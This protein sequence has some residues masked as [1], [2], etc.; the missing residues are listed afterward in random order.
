VNATKIE[1]AD[2]R[3]NPITGCPGPKI[4]PGCDHCY[5]E[6][7]AKRLAGRYGY[8]RQDPFSLHQHHDRWL[9]P[10]GIKKPSRI[11]VCSMGDLFHHG[12]FD[13]YIAWVFAVMAMCPQHTFMLLTKRPDRLRGFIMDDSTYA[14]D[15]RGNAYQRMAAA[16]GIDRNMDGLP[17]P[18][19]NVWLGVTVCNQAEAKKQI[20]I[21]LE[22]PAAKRFVSVEPML[23]PVDLT[24]LFPRSDS[25]S[26][27]IIDWVICGGETGPRARPMHPGWPRALRD[28][29]L[30]TGVP[31]LFKGNGEWAEVESPLPGDLWVLPCGSPSVPWSL[32]TQGAPAGR[33]STWPDLPMRRVGKKHAGRLLGGMEHN[34]FPGSFADFIIRSLNI[35][36]AAMGIP[37]DWLYREIPKKETDND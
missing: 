37:R 26:A 23:G 18:L 27:D 17:W 1:W 29:C 31:F 5:A 25:G 3:W 13:F 28:Q 34:A 20:P 9:E 35:M 24:R 30:D 36:A 2:K 19:P 7:M 21:L 33:W 6:R 4:S 22:T 15:M 11:F 16:A 8:D 14:C 12:V 10:L 32:D